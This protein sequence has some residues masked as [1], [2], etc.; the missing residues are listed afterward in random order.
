MRAMVLAAGLGTRLRP[1][2]YELPKPMVPVLDRPVMAHIVDLLGRHGIDEV[3]ANLHYFPDTIRDYFGDQL[4]YRQEAQLLGTA[5][6]VR[7]CADFF[8]SDTF[9]VI[10]GDA[11][12]DINLDALAATHRATGSI[13]TIAVKR[14]IDTREYGVVIHDAD[15]QITGFQEKPEPEDAQSDL[16]NCGI[17]MFEPEIFDYFPAVDPVDWALDVFPE[18]LAAGAPFHVHETHSYWNDVGSL[19]ELRQGTFDALDGGLEIE[20]VGETDEVTGITVCAGSALD[21]KAVASLPIW[22]GH[23]VRIGADVRLHGPVVVGDGATLGDGVC[24]RETIVLPGTKVPDRA[25]LIGAI[26]G[27]AGILESLR[28]RQ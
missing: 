23:D 21:A 1:L 11:L 19:A 17:Y 27:H 12:T 13:A 3:I 25:I 5:G 26:A 2:T 15:G 9:L 18:L 10:S 22:I 16:G 7:N 24:L 6:G 8:G 4:S 20:P 28:P 14:V